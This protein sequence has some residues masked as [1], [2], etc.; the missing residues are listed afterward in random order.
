M[1]PDAINNLAQ[2]WDKP[3]GV[4]S[5]SAVPGPIPA[6]DRSFGDW[7]TNNFGNMNL[8]QMAGSALGGQIGSSLAESYF[9]AKTPATD[10][11][12]HLA[13]VGPV[14][15]NIGGGSASSNGPIPYGAPR[16]PPAG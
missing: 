2:A 7:F 10:L 12:P 6:P 8:K 15:T 11:G 4:L 13:P 14:S 16:K 3:G 1:S 9:P 5:Q